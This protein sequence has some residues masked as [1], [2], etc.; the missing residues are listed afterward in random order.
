MPR[1]ELMKIRVDFE[2]GQPVPIKFKYVTEEK[3]ILTVTVLRITKRD[4]N[5]FAGNRMLVYL[6]E[7]LDTKDIVKNYELRYELDSCKWYFYF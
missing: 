7:S 3:E 2:D 1:Q 6:C 5:N 4:I